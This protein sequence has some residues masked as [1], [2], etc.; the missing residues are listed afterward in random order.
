MNKPP[1]P[2]TISELLNVPAWEYFQESKL[3]NDLFISDPDRADRIHEAAEDGCDGSTHAEH[4]EDWR[5]FADQLKDDCSSYAY[6][7]DDETEAAAYELEY[8]AAFDALAEAIDKCEAYHE[9]QGIIH[10]QVG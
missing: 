10:E 3:G 9:E 2:R 8:E 7:M 5:E 4:I 6:R 1:M